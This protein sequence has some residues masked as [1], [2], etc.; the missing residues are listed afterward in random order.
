[1]GRKTNSQFWK[2]KRVLITGH[3]GFLGS[4]LTK[5]LQ[6]YGARV[7][8]IDKAK[9]RLLSVIKG[10]RRKIKGIKG[11]IANAALV[12][13]IINRDKPQFIF[14]I[15]AE[16][17][18]NRANKNPLRTFKSNIQG[19]WNILEAAKGK[20]FIEG[21]VVAS[22]DKAYGSHKKLPYKE[23]AALKGEHPYD[24]SKSCTD[25]LC[26]SYFVTFNV[27]VCVTRCGNIYGPGDFNFSRLIPDAIRHILRHKQFV[28]RSD[29]KFTRDYIFV[30][31]IVEAYLVLA[32]NIAKRKLAGEAFN[33]SNEKPLSV[34]D[35]FNKIAQSC[36][37]SRAI[38]PKILNRAQHEIQHQYLSS[39]KAKDLLGWKAG[40]SFERGLKETV[41]WYQANLKA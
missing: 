38:K 33:F 12:N 37:G 15:A 20:D 36:N 4:W 22:S 3:E 2:D 6:E 23:E 9:E 39:R 27:P 24:V 32:E 29:G 19:T 1:M 13:K 11:D 31:D 26:R 8:G 10:S 17:I 40:Y 16:A 28:I 7:V 25:L 5:T 14:H 18:V 41:S 34:L 30:K 21:I 35:A